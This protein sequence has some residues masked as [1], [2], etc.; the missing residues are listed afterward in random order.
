VQVTR[1]NIEIKYDSTQFKGHHN[2]Q[3]TYYH[4]FQ[5][6]HLIQV[7]Y[8][9][10]TLYRELFDST[11]I[12]YDAVNSWDLLYIA[13]PFFA[14]CMYVKKK[15]DINISHLIYFGP[16]QFNAIQFAI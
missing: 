4:R 2:I 13:V 15:L 7:T 14:Y 1:L 16:I 6:G 8:I 3:T 5:T 11:V 9:Y 12:F 10:S